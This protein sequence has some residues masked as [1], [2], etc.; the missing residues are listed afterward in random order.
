MILTARGF[1]PQVDPS[2]FV[3][4]NASLIAD[5]Q[6]GER[7]SIW[8][9]CV[10]RGDVMPIRI[11]KEV[12]IQDNS[13]L[14]GTYNKCGVTIHDR[15]T[16]GHSVVLHG[17]EIGFETLIGMGSI[18]MDQALVPA[19][20]IVGAGSL[21]TENAKFEEYSL[22]V[23]RPAKFVRKLTPKEIEFLPKSA[24]NYLEYMRWY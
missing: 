23:G 24:N 20:C 7:S 22:I 6:I 12:N 9:G 15:V 4:P 16:I 8:F 19:H 2:C 14:H 10:L 3:A 21:V 11:G 5:V 17:C 13:V 18:V 1:T